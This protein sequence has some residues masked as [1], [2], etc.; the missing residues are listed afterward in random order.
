[1][2]IWNDILLLMVIGIWYRCGLKLR[3]VTSVFD[4][5]DPKQESTGPKHM[6]LRCARESSYVTDTVHMLSNHHLFLATVNHLMRIQRWNMLT[7]K[8]SVKYQLL[9]NLQLRIWQT[10]LDYQIILFA[11]IMTII[12]FCSTFYVLPASF[13]LNYRKLQM[14]LLSPLDQQFL[15]HDQTMKRKKRT[16]DFP[17]SFMS[18]N[19]M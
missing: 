2:F 14:H 6:R 7:K 16:L 10:I 5:K 15:Y 11:I 9:V 1:M 18:P 3:E 8:F 17:C 4:S 13:D 12:Y 19:Y